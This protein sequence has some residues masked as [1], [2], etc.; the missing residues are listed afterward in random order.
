M[1]K[2]TLIASVI[3]LFTSG[4]SADAPPIEGAFGI[5]FGDKP[6][7]AY[8][9]EKIPTKEGALYFVDPPVKNENF[10]EY[11]VLVTNTTNKIHRIYAEKQQ[12]TRDC[13]AE[14]LKVK[15]A[16]EKIYGSMTEHHHVY[17][18]KHKDQEINLTCKISNLS[19][20]TASLQIKYIDHQIF[21]ESLQ[22]PDPDRGDASGL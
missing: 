19:R 2:S 10:N 5:K 17:V 22:K 14:I 21:K 7:H 9:A 16:L 12:S 3:L 20:N 4:V 11:A 6:G 8:R 15:Q 1:Q 18:I 13:K